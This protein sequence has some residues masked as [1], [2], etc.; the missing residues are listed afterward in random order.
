[1]SG[2]HLRWSNGQSPAH[3]ESCSVPESFFRLSDLFSRELRFRF[4]SIAK[5]L[6]FS[7]SQAQQGLDVRG[8]FMMEQRT[9]SSSWRELFGSGKLLQTFGPLLSGTTVPLYLDSQVAVMA[10]G[11]DIPSYPC[12]IFG[13][14][15]ILELQ[16][17]V[18]WIYDI[19]E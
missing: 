4:I 1:M 10:L 19:T 12:K 3:G 8:S 2:V 5:W 15:K 7:V 18:S 11:G 17:L 6:L 13:S 14:S 9:K 16:D